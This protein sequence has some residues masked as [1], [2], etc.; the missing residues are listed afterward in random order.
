MALNIVLI[1]HGAIASSALTLLRPDPAGVEVS[2]GICRPGREQ[3][4][5]AIFGEGVPVVTSIDQLPDST[6]LVVDCAGHGGLR[7]HAEPALLRGF[8]VLTV[9]IGALTDPDLLSRLIDAASRGGSRLNLASGAIGALDALSAAAVG[10]LDEVVY[11]GRKSPKAWQGSVAEETLDLS[12]PLP[13][14]V[15]HFAGTAGEAASRY[16]KN[17]NVAAAVALAGIGFEDTTVE[18]WAD[19]GVERSTHTIDATGRFGKLRFEIAGEPMTENTRSSALTAMSVV[20]HIR[21][22]IAPL[23]F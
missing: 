3:A 19:S 15:C 21:R 12:A 2:G 13:E 5:F 14:P 8:D 18:L 9:S 4:A 1:G 7:Q 22:L 11:R 10:G 20:A 23:S 17:A 16:P 6:D